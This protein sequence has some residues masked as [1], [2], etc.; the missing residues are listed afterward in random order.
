M[1][2]EVA[3]LGYFIICSASLEAA[4]DYVW[5]SPPPS[6]VPMTRQEYRELVLQGEI[7][8]REEAFRQQGAARAALEKA[9][10]LY[11]KG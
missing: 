9:Q 1:F 8:L 10:K 4:S 7:A 3:T 11:G 5:K 2:K 6:V